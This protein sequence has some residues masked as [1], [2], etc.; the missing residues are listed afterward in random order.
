MKL[1]LLRI[2]DLHRDP[3]NP[4][5]ND[6]LLDSV[7]N[8]RRHYSAEET[9]RVQPPDLII[10]SGDIIHGIMADEADPETKLREQYQEAPDFLN[11]LTE[12]FVMGDRG[13]VVIVP[14]NHGRLR[15]TRF[16]RSSQILR[17]NGQRVCGTSFRRSSSHPPPILVALRRSRC[18]NVL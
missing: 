2:S 17:P 8:D 4:I 12:Q 9:P 14:G 7:E 18:E 5:R 13:R 11:R 10:V 1:S 3:E 15:R 6:I 16:N